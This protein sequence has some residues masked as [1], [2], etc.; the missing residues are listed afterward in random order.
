MKR[1]P[2]SLIVLGLL[3]LA[4]SAQAEIIRNKKQGHFKHLGSASH[5]SWAPARYQSSFRYDIFYYIPR[6]LKSASQVPALMFLHGGGTST[7][8]RMGSKSAVHLYLDEMVH[9]ADRLGVVVVLPSANGLNW[10]SHT[11]GLVRDLA[12]MIRTEL[13]VD[14]NRIG[15]SGHSMGGMGITR[16]YL[17]ESD[18]FA[19][20]LPMSAGMDVATQSEQQLNKVFNVPYVHLQGRADEF[21]I[22]VERCEEQVKRTKELEAKYGVSSKLEMTFTDDDHQ[23]DPA[24]FE[25][26]AQALFKN[27]PRKLYQKELW[28]SLE[29]V[30]D[31]PMENKITFD[32]DSEARYFWIE[33]L[34]SNLAVHER[35][36]FHAKIRGNRIDIEMSVL[37]KQSKRL[38]LYLHSEMV[39][40]SKKTDIYLNGALVATREAKAGKLRN[41]DANDPG[42]L[43][44]D[45]VEFALPAL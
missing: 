27:S 10:G 9:L 16:S 33:L 28:G 17:W 18:E 35:T 2:A 23:Y 42:F 32:L 45:I 41:L 13:D 12:Q 6:A 39:D 34:D 19:F 36:D 31:R 37:P 40:L 8:T 25:K 21:Q 11:R 1:A 5:F 14:S 22:F 30:H 26:K 44:E 43:F 24:L 29:T 20:F 38:R 15:L 7:L 3:A 4:G